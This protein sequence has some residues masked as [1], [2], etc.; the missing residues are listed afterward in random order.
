[1]VYMHAVVSMCARKPQIKH[2]RPC[3]L[4]G[5]ELHAHTELQQAHTNSCQQYNTNILFEVYVTYVLAL[6]VLP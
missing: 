3:I 2:M 4:A 5:T 6:T 1:M